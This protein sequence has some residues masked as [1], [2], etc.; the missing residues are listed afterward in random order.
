MSQLFEN[1]QVLELMSDLKHLGFNDREAITI[2]NAIES[3]E[4]RHL[5]IQNQEH[6]A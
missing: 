5:N 6:A 3:R 4:L 1:E 2:I